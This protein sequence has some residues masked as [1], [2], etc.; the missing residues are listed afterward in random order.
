MTDVDVQKLAE[1][2][3]IAISDDEVARLEKEIPDILHFVEQIQE[4]GAEPRKEVG[5]LYNVLR[6]DEH[7]HEPGMYT[8]D[9]L[10]TMPQ[11]KDGYLKVRK[12]ISQD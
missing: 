8:E 6:E 11:S 2:S 3:R 9:I 4:A 12:I 10:K 5:A 1:L 7:P